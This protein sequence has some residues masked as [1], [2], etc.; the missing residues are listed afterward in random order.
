MPSLDTELNIIPGDEDFLLNFG[1]IGA[2]EQIQTIA[3]RLYSLDRFEKDSNE[4]T[5]MGSPYF[6]FLT[7]VEIEAVPSNRI[8]F[9]RIG[10]STMEGNI[11][12]NRC[13]NS[14]FI[15]NDSISQNLSVYR[16]PS[17][18]RTERSVD[19]NIFDLSEIST[20]NPFKNTTNTQFK[21][22]IADRINTLSLEISL[23]DNFSDYVQAFK[24]DANVSP[25]DYKKLKIRKAYSTELRGMNRKRSTGV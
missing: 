23:G 24:K 12:R 18:E 3:N 7:E 5:N 4:L 20:V 22:I 2:S 16:Q 14:F 19:D 25:E 17:D 13:Y 6:N 10:D 11:I 21:T 9:G 15:L 1:N 8:I